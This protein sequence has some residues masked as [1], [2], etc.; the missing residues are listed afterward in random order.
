[1]TKKNP[2]EQDS[3]PE[4]N[5]KHR[6]TGAAVLIFFGVLVIPWLLGPP[7]EASKRVADTDDLGVVEAADSAEL[8]K[9][10]LSELESSGEEPDET[11]YISK[12]TPLDAKQGES[13]AD[14]AKKVSDQEVVQKKGSDDKSAASIEESDK[15]SANAEA[16]AKTDNAVK[17][18][19]QEQ[20]RLA[21]V[22]AEQEQKAKAE[23]LAKEQRARDKKRKVDEQREKE[24]QAALAAESAKKSVKP[25]PVS[26]SS[27]VDV[28]WVVQVGLYL[29]KKGAQLKMKELRSQGFKP[30]STVVDTNRGPK[31]GTR[32]WLGPF[33]KR[34]EAEQENSKL[35]NRTKKDGFI[36]VY[37]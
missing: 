36:R 26:S 3:I 2:S 1:M 5:I 13:L 31:T 15:R 10:L 14:A 12:I 21:K 32:V 37:P 28:G 11:V 30:S 24:L 23:R 6:I 25:A 19:K 20:E 22:K 16:Q 33:A 7:S 27:R 29:E 8:E 34:S 35:V 18:A 9:Q 17:K 4:F